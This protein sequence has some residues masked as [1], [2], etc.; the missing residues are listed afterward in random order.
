[1]VDMPSAVL[2]ADKGDY[3]HHQLS[4]DALHLTQLTSSVSNPSVR[5]PWLTDLSP[6]TFNLLQGRPPWNE[7]TSDVVLFELQ[8]LLCDSVAAPCH[9]VEEDPERADFHGIDTS[10]LLSLV[11]SLK[12]RLH[13]NSETTGGTLDTIFPGEESVVILLLL[14]EHRM[15]DVF[16]LLLGSPHASLALDVALSFCRN[17]VA[18]DWKMLM[19]RLFALSQQ[20][21]HPMWETFSS[22]FVRTLEHLCRNVPPTVFVEV[23]PE[24]G[25][26]CFLLPFIETCFSSQHEK[27]L[28]KEIVQ[29]ERLQ[30]FSLSLLPLCEPFNSPSMC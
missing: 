18:T 5:Y 21:E 11:Y 1:M 9:G 19:D 14:L 8:N 7:R 6:A 20:E 30:G 17:D 15:G 24:E 25:D 13:A 3:S 4:S 16:D 22:L 2:S 29:Q 27:R 12:E 28:R 26:M 23:L 10:E